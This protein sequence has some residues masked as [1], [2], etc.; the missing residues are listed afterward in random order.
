MAT[1]KLLEI[2]TSENGTYTDVTDIIT[3]GEFTVTPVQFA[4]K[5]AQSPLTGNNYSGLVATKWQLSSKCSPLTQAQTEIILP[6]V[7]PEYI[8]VNYRNP[9][10]GWKT[11]VKM[12]SGN[13]PATAMTMMGGVLYWNGIS[14]MLV[15]V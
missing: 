9:R 2:A 6:L 3:P 5:R 1:Y 14:F 13:A 11:G 8:W 7:A 15:E 12:M 10:L 4:P